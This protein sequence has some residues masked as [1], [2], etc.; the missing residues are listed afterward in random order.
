MVTH[1]I[2]QTNYDNISTL[3]NLVQFEDLLQPEI[4][5]IFEGLDRYIN[6][7]Y[8]YMKNQIT[9]LIDSSIEYYDNLKEE[10]KRLFRE[11][12]TNKKKI[13]K[14]FFNENEELELEN[15]F[16]YNIDELISKTNNL[17]KNI[18][19]YLLR[20]KFEQIKENDSNILPS[21]A[22]YERGVLDNSF[23]ET[24]YDNFTNNTENLI[25]I[26]SNYANDKNNSKIENDEF[27]G[28]MKISYRP[29][30]ISAFYEK[31]QN[32][33]YDEELYEIIPGFQYICK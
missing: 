19:F 4:E 22:G 10:I 23:G 26:N 24:V 1:N 13:V 3:E 5:K 2:I 20:E 12:A 30:D 15:V 29:E 14:S 17:N 31:I 33:D 18:N 21:I 8:D 16:T 6:N 27:N 25:K 9:P 7:I 32:H 11:Y 28:L